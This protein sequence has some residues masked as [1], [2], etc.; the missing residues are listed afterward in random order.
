MFAVQTE[1]LSASLQKL[2]N[3]LPI[4]TQEEKIIHF[5]SFT[6]FKGAKLIYSL[7]S[8]LHHSVSNNDRNG[9]GEEEMAQW[10]SLVWLVMVVFNI[11]FTTNTVPYSFYN[12]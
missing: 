8:L 7:L 2:Q 4:F 3:T 9:T 10:H 11:A 1:I 6:D 12:I 5:Y